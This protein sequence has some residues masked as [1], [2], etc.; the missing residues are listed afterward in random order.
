MDM[1]SLARKY[2]VDRL[3]VAAH[4][5]RAGVELRYQGLP[6][7][8]VAEAAL[9]YAEGWSLKRLEQRF[10]CSSETMRKAL[11]AHGV[12]MRKPWERG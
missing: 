5:R 9:L 1:R 10:A 6:D 8:Q 2:G 4:L 11:K 3:T 7:D 12:I